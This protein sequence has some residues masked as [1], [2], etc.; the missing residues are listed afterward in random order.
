MTTAAQQPELA[1]PTDGENSVEWAAKHYLAAKV[2][3]KHILNYNGANMAYAHAADMANRLGLTEEQKAKITPFPANNTTIVV[4]GGEQ[5]ETAQ[6]TSPT[7]PAAAEP[8]KASGLHPLVKN[9]LIAALGAGA[10]PLA[11][12]AYQ[13]YTQSPAVAPIDPPAVVQPVD[14]GEVGYEVY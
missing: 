11:Y 14:P 8:A 7:P 3:S 1:M 10:V 5:Q 12:G 9:A 6:E 4:Q 2:Q 13:H